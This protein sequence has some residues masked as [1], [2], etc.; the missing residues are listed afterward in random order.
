[1][2]Y[3]AIALC[4]VL[5]GCSVVGEQ[6]RSMR[7]CSGIGR[8]FEEKREEEYRPYYLKPTQSDIIQAAYFEDAK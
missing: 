2:R 5:A 4:C 6:E 8:I 1:M 7:F 3:V